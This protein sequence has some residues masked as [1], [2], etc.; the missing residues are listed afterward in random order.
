MTLLSAPHATK[1]LALSVAI[2]ASGMMDAGRIRHHLFHGLP[3]ANNAVLIVG[4]CAP[5]TLGAHLL[6]KPDVV[7]MYG[8]DV[9]VR[10]A[11]LTMG[12]YSAHGDRNELLQ[13]I[14]CQDPGLVNKVFLVHGTDES[15]AGL[16]TLYTQ[17]G[18]TH[19]DLPKQGQRFEV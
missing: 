1:V 9:P 11:I 17:H 16:R 19:I 13:W 12:S 18:F 14:G 8:E 3:N 5:G 10:A 4:F 6:E 2:A 7:H 15:M